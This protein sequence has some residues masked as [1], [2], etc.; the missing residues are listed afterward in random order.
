MP[1]VP[2]S[3]GGP[4]LSGETG[5]FEITTA[6]MLA[7]GRFSLGLSWSMW[8]RTAA[9]VPGYVFDRWVIESG[10]PVLGDSKSASTSLGALSLFNR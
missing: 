6:D 5:L 1:A 7:A 10:S 3:S 9:P 2:A 4:T 8:P